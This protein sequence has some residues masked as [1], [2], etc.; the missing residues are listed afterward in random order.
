MSLRLCV[1]LKIIFF[2]FSF[3]SR[4]VEK[5]EKKRMQ[6][7]LSVCSDVC[8][9]A[10]RAIFIPAPRPPLWVQFHVRNRFFPLWVVFGPREVDFCASYRVD[11]RSQFL[12]T[13]GWFWASET[14][15]GNFELDFEPLGVVLGL[16]ESSSP[17]M[18]RFWVLTVDF[19]HLRIILDLRDRILVSGWFWVPNDQFWSFESQFRASDIRFWTSSS[20]CW[21]S[22]SRF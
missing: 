13:K 10:A 21:T 7:C 14:R 16:W 15:F 11:F 8:A 9:F 6:W 2:L 22:R 4:G 17:H 12:E 5:K 1:R 3:F 20:W 18:S 19:R